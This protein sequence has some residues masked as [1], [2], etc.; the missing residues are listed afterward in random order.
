MEIWMVFVAI[1]LLMVMLELI[2]GVDT[3]LD[4]VFLGTAFIIGGLVGLPFSSWIP[5]LL[6]TT[7]IGAAYVALGR[8]YVHRWTAVRKSRT[9][10]DAIIGKTG[11]VAQKITRDVGGRVKVGGEDWKASAAE[12]IE[13]GSKVV[14]TGITGATLI[15]ERI[16]EV[17]T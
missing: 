13:E 6:V 8:R 7:A 9:N 3:G 11:I 16:R 15:V 1:G 17:S 14:V 2:V 12:D 10:V 5:P 4:L